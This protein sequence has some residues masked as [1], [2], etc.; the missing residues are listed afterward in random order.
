VSG[1]ISLLEKI[2]PIK[3]NPRQKRI[4]LWSHKTALLSLPSWGTS[5]TGEQ[6]FCGLRSPHSWSGRFDSFWLLSRRSSDRTRIRQNFNHQ[7]KYSSFNVS[8]LTS[9]HFFWPLKLFGPYCMYTSVQFSNP[10]NSLDHTVCIQVSNFLTLETVWTIL[11]VYKCPIFWPLKQFGPYCMYT[12]VQFSNPWN[13]LDHTVCIQVS[14][15][16]A[17]ETVRTIC[18][19][20]SRLFEEKNIEDITVYCVQQST[21]VKNGKNWCNMY[22]LLWLIDFRTLGMFCIFVAS[23]PQ[24][25]REYK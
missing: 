3:Y 17:L 21:E 11:Y 18:I 5:S 7:W 4:P 20:Y 12:S 10:W 9:V 19:H 13:S 22:I 8:R 15:F 1:Q 16:L 14:N 24:D 23:T 6:I 2:F 25:A